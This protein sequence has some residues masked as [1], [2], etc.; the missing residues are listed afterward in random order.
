MGLFRGPKKVTRE[1]NNKRIKKT[2]T[3]VRATVT[4]VI[5]KRNGYIVVA[6]YKDRWLGTQYSYT[7]QLLKETPC[8]SIGGE[9]MVYVDDLAAEGEY[10]VEC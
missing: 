5:V 7:S 9:V 10:Y 6:L 3:P 2:G 1:D 8:V 4:D